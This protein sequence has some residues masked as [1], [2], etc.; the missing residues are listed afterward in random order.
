MMPDQNEGFSQ[1]IEDARALGLIFSKEH[2]RVVGQNVRLGLELYE[3]VRKE[4]ASIVQAASLR[5]RTDMRERFG[6]SSASDQPGK[7]TLEWLC[8]YNMVKHVQ[9]VVADVGERGDAV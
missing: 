8:E 4:R 6:W 2:A 9:Q 1:A 5:A 3:K 7:L